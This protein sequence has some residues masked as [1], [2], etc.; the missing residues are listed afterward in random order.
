MD[1]ERRFCPVG[2]KPIG[3]R[4]LISVI[5]PVYNYEKFVS[6]AISSVLGQTYDNLE[7]ILC[8]DG[9]ADGSVAIAREFARR[10]CRM[11]II[12]KSN[13]GQASALNAAFKEHRGEIVCVL[14]ADDLF[15][16]DKLQ[17][18]ADYYR[19]HPD[20]GVVVHSM[21][22]LNEHGK[23]ADTIPFLSKFEQGWIGDKVVRR[24]GRW[25]YMPSSA[26]SFRDELAP[27]WFPIPEEEFRVNA[28]TFIF[29][30]LPLFT[31]VGYIR[32]PLSCYR[33]HDSNM[34][35]EFCFN[36]KTLRYQ[37][38]CMRI[39]NA[40]VNERLQAL[41]YPQRLDLSRNL[42]F[43]VIR[44][45]LHMLEDRS[46]RVR[47][48]CYRDILALA[49]G[50]DLMGIGGKALVLAGHGASLLLPLPGRR[51]V[52]NSMLSPSP[53]KRFLQSFRR[54]PKRQEER[55]KG[56]NEQHSPQDS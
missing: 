30:I 18:L 37:E 36:P 24:G 33:M 20:V 44:F 41:G 16:P 46:L 22:L 32:E 45:K 13:G 55:P 35:G 9:S 34:S 39:P 51:W 4:P 38:S 3:A 8:D 27:Y 28:E 10:D 42:D 48:R 19:K 6:G 17:R 43:A 31:C 29:T 26:L 2:L 56:R 21:I 52:F 54:E 5:V 50:D 25:R 14:D 7:L 40:A 12:E 15:A 47:L 1:G 53:I 23:R 11:R 49:L